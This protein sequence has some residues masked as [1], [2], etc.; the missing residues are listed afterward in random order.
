[1]SQISVERLIAD[2]VIYMLIAELQGHCSFVSFGQVSVEHR[3]L[4][5]GNKE[6]RVR[7][8]WIYGL[9]QNLLQLLNIIK[10]LFSVYY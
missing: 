4:L 9:N 7:T 6:F 2:T 5:V 1:V 3:Y 8:P 10:F